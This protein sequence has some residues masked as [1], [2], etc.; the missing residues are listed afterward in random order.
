MKRWKIMDA[1]G[2]LALSHTPGQFGGHKKS[3][4]YGRLDCPAALRALSKGGYV[5]DRVFFID[6]QT[7]RL[8]GYRPCFRC[9]PARYREWKLTTEGHLAQLGNTAKI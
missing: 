3:R 4:I 8:A 7:A 9:M 1:H 6:E 2:K 5:K